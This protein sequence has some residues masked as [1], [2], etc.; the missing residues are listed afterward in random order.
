MRPAVT[1][2]DH[3]VGMIQQF[4]DQLV[5]VMAHVCRQKVCFEVFFQRNI[6]HHV[7]RI[8]T[9]SAAIAS[10]FSRRRFGWRRTVPDATPNDS[11]RHHALG[12]G[13]QGRLSVRILQ[14]GDDCS[15]VLKRIS[16]YHLGRRTNSKLGTAS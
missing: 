6:N 7:Q 15:G 10:A 9:R 13:N 4:T 1:G 3:H 8:A 5:V 11:T 12:L 14:A 2:A 16:A